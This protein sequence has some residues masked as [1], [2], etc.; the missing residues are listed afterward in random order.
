MALILSGCGIEN[1]F[2]PTVKTEIDEEFK[3]YVDEFYER[4]GSQDYYLIVH[5][6]E[7]DTGVASCDVYENG[8]L[9]ITVK[10]ELWITFCEAQKRALIFHEMGHCILDRDHVDY[11]TLSYMVPSVMSCTYYTQNQ[12]E[13]D[14]ELFS[15]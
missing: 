5:F 1:V 7:L 11:E 9:L 8:Q 2:S 3:P 10:E 12:E 4:H 13:L 15:Y 6:G 14:R